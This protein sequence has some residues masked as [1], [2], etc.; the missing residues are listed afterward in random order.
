MKSIILILSTI[1]LVSC[2]RPE[3]ESPEADPYF[4]GEWRR[5]DKV[6]R[7]GSKLTSKATLFVMPQTLSYDASLVVTAPL[8]YQVDDCYYGRIISKD[9]SKFLD[10]NH[11]EI[12]DCYEN[13]NNRNLVDIVIKGEIL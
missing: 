5:N 4:Q 6:H 8:N 3:W 9:Q 2:G 10:Y 7:N 13:I 11:Y 1:F 12:V